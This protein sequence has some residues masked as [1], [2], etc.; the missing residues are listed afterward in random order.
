MDV[1]LQIIQTVGFPVAACVFL[2][3][4]IKKQNDEYRADVRTI[5]E[6]YENA[7]EKFSNS[8]DK[9]TRVLTALDAKLSTNEKGEND[10]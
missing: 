6:K 7:I 5:T 10:K 4:F 8:I 1:V 2:G 3:Y 9:N